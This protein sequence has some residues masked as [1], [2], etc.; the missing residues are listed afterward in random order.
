MSNFIRAVQNIALGEFRP[1]HPR[2]TFEHI[3]ESDKPSYM[4]TT[5]VRKHLLEVKWELIF[6]CPDDHFTE[7]RANAMKQLNHDLYSDLIQWHLELTA[8]IYAEDF[9]RSIELLGVI[10][11]ELG[12]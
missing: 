5:G 6:W 10:K 8:A 3:A 12:M 1:R 4:H 2:I 7:A 11:K 9:T